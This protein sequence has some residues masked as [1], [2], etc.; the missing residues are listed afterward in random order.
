MNFKLIF[1]ILLIN[2]L[3]LLEC[4]DQEYFDKYKGYAFSVKN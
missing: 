4:L 2:T 1:L 3:G